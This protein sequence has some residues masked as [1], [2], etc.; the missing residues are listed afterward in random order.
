[1][2]VAGRVRTLP[3]PIETRGTPTSGGR[4]DEQFAIEVS[5]VR[6]GDVVWCRAA[7]LRSAGYARNR[8]RRNRDRDPRSSSSGNPFSAHTGYG[9]VGNGTRHGNGPSRNGRNGN[10]TCGRNRRSEHGNTWSEWHGRG[11]RRA[12]Y[13]ERRNAGDRHANDRRRCQRDRGRERYPRASRGQQRN[14][15]RSWQLGPAR[16]SRA[17][18]APWPPA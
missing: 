2:V 10:S 16:S 12:R 18:R 15:R 13:S 7:G 9:P 6:L 1:M 17:L 8:C 3:L 5:G 11:S 14:Q 4:K